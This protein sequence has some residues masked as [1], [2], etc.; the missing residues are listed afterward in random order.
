[1]TIDE[2]GQWAASMPLPE[3]ATRDQ[4][5]AYAGLGLCGE[6]GEI[7]DTIRRS[8]RD[9]TLNE[10]RLVYELGDLVYHWVCL[11]V[12]LGCSPSAMLA[13]SRANIE[14]RLAARS[15]STAAGARL[16]S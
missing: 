5:L 2:F 11:C 10:D 4:R 16:S 6:A 15:S 9:G 1:M 12:E 3:L 14:T 13:T 7:A 8:T